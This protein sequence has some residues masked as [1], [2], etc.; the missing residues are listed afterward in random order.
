MLPVQGIAHFE[1]L[2]RRGTAIKGG[3]VFRRNV[4]NRMYNLLSVRLLGFGRI[5]V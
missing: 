1:T 4:I 2:E 5:S 3:A